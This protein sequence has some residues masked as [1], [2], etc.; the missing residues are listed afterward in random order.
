MLQA[1]IDCLFILSFSYNFQPLTGVAF[2]N[3]SPK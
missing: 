2:R 1:D 3:V